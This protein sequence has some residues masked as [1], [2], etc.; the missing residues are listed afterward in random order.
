MHMGMVN[1]S[2]RRN[3]L[4]SCIHAWVDAAALWAVSDLIEKINFDP[5]VLD[6]KEG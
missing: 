1:V 5:R 4:K 3:R 6:E 2:W